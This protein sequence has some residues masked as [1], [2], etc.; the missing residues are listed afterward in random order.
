MPQICLKH[1]GYVENVEVLRKAL[2]ES[3]I[4]RMTESV[5]GVVKQVFFKSLRDHRATA[6]V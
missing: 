1:F 4:S 5:M 2:V 6:V 3:C